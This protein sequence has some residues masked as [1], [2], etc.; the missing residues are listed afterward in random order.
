MLTRAGGRGRGSLDRG[1]CRIDHLAEGLRGPAAL[2]DLL[3][4]GPELPPG[5]AR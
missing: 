5:Q 1:G 2:G 4:P 3:S